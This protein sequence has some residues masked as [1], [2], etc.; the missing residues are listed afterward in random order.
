MAV[1]EDYII[2]SNIKIRKFSKDVLISELEWHRDKFNRYIEILSGEGWF[3]Q[4]EDC[5]PI[6][7]VKG[8][9]LF[10]PAATYHRIKRGST[11]LIIKIIEHSKRIA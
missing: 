8:D 1:Y 11:D 4:M 5:L 10:I 6:E 7:L 9:Y 2:N 3:F